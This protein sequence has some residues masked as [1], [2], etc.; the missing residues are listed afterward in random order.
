MRIL[1]QRF[2]EYFKEHSTVE[3]KKLK[4]MSLKEKVDYIWEYYKIPIIGVTIFLFIAASIINNI[5]NPP[6]PSYAAIA[7]YEIFIP[8]ETSN[9]LISRLT[10]KLIEDPKEYQIYTHSLI[11]GGDPT[12]E[13]AII[14]KLMAMVMVSEIDLLVADEEMFKG[15][16][17]EGFF[18]D[19]NTV[20][21]TVPDELI[22]SGYTIDDPEIRPYGINLGNSR[23]LYEVGIIRPERLNIGII[24]SSE[25]TDNAINILNAL[26]EG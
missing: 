16:L 8:D 18:M 22:I 21:I 15:F 20:G 1:W 7:F 11:A 2:K 23:L 3:K 14:Q 9:E 12:A 26:L 24:I 6:T 5:M 13:M 4:D 19:L 25:A 10:K 17:A